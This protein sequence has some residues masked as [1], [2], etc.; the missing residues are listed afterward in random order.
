M[1]APVPALPGLAAP[2]ARSRF[3]AE[4][5]AIAVN[6]VVPLRADP[7]IA[8]KNV[9][10]GVAAVC[11]YEAHLMEHLPAVDLGELRSLPELARDVVE[12]ARV[13]GGAGDEER[14]LL[15]EA[16]ALRR[17]LRSAAL[18]LAEAGVLS[19][20]DVAKLGKGRGPVDVGAE[21]ATLSSLFQRRAEE[22]A[23]KT[24]ATSPRW[25]APPR[26][27]RRSAR[28]CGRRDR[29]ASRARTA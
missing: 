28:S 27:A 7:A 10:A 14:D 1:V 17:T 12:A 19:A 15:G 26:W 21:C 24:G 16:D 18:A 9:A 5:R 2:P 25:S 4:A 13:A 22:V 6:E 29:R 23:D 3:L 20:R 11:A 8:K